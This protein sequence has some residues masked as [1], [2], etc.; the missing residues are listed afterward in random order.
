LL[1]RAACFTIIALP[2]VCCLLLLINFT[3]CVAHHVAVPFRYYLLLL[4]LS[5]LLLPLLPLPPLLLPHLTATHINGQPNLQHTNVGDNYDHAM[6]TTIHITHDQRNPCINTTWPMIRY[7]THDT[8][9]V[10]HDNM[11]MEHDTFTWHMTYETRHDITWPMTM[12][13]MKQPWHMTPTHG[14]RDIWQMTHDIW[15]MTHDTWHMTP[16]TWH[17]TWHLKLTYDI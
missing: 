10:T 7:T 15:H 8:R 16:G 3:L 2:S 1:V 14:P 9:H 17:D 5:L 12:L 6:N 11:T 13:N 4:L